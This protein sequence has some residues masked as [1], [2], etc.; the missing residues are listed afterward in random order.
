MLRACMLVLPCIFMGSNGVRTSFLVGWLILGCS[1]SFSIRSLTSPST[2]RNFLT[3]IGLTISHPVRR[4]GLRIPD[5]LG[6]LINTSI[7]REE[8]HAAHASN[9][10]L[11]PSILILESLVDQTV[12]LDVRREVVRH[13]IV[14]AMVRDAV[15]ERGEPTG[16]AEG[17]RFDGGEHLGEVRVQLEGAVV[18]RVPEVLDVLGQVAEE[19][20]VGVAD[21]AG[22]FDL[23][24]C[25]WFL[26]VGRGCIG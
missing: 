24:P 22:D 8:P 13:Q 5:L 11:Q 1:Q 21:L 25:Q 20:D 10:L 26:G 12:G 4:Q 7:A 16:V 15:A 14:I 17:S 23:E 2:R 18:V 9:A 19:E 6:I 3:S